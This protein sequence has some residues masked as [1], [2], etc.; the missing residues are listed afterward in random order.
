MLAAVVYFAYSTLRPLTPMGERHSLA[1]R[2]AAFSYAC[3]VVT[4]A[5]S[6][7]YHVYSA[8]RF[9]SAATRLV[10]YFGI[11]LGI[12]SG[13]FSDMAVVTRNL[14][15][16]SWA[17]MADVW[18]AMALLVVFFAVRRSTLSVEETRLAY[19]A[20]KCSL[21][22]A[23][24]TNV[25]LEHS[26]LR[27]AA[28]TIMAFSWVLMV[29]SAFQTLEPE[30]AWVFAGSRFV[31]TVILVA[32]MLLDNAILYPD[33]WFEGNEPPHTCVCYSRARGPGGGWIMTAHALWH[34]IA[35]VSTVVTTAGTEYVL[36]NSHAL[37]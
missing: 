36:V 6:V 9:W 32:G 21:G 16:A 8:N 22:L 27:A 37:Q 15:G 7:V 33:S 31:G 24:S 29:P 13:T 18:I 17:S 28:G 35:L 20:S 34:I 4:F 19:M 3:F 23:R 26:S 25:D 10:D 14:T 11:Y 2:L 1:S 30:C 12:A 5:S